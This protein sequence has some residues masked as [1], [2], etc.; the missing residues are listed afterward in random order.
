MPIIEQLVVAVVASMLV[1]VGVRAW[2]PE[3]V[4]AY[5]AY[6]PAISATMVILIIGGVT[7]AN[8]AIIRSNVSLLAGIGV[9]VVV[10]NT[11]GYGIGFVLSRGESRSTRIAS[12]LS[13]GMRDF[14]VAVALVIAA[15]LPTI[16][17]LPAVAFGVV[18]MATS[19]G[20]AQ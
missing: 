9:G 16:T 3:R 4:G 20:L 15:G 1:A 5:H 8:A 10:L 7:A 2:Q 13:I 19:A 14:A 18:E 12:V 11:L 17:S 6:Y